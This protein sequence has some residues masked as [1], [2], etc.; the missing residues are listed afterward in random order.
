[1]FT[2]YSV[3]KDLGMFNEKYIEIYQD[4]EY[5][6][7]SIIRGYTNLFAGNL[8][9]YHYESQ[10]RKDG[11]NVIYNSNKD[12]KNTFFPFVIRNYRHFKKYF[13]NPIHI[14]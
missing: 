4:V 11:E 12:S 14:I 6:L 9:A 8:V 7:I 2:P 1:M 3:F 10:T 13:S 5:N